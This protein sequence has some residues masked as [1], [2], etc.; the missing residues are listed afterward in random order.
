MSTRI[1]TWPARTALAHPAGASSQAVLGPSRD[2][3][4]RNP[5]P[6]SG[7]L[8]QFLRL[9]THLEALELYQFQPGPACVC[10]DLE[11]LLDDVCRYWHC[12]GQRP[13]HL[14][15]TLGAVAGQTLPA[16]LRRQSDARPPGAWTATAGLRVAVA[17]SI[18]VV[19][20]DSVRSPAFP[21][22]NL[23]LTR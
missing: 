1:S 12:Y 9:G 8:G 13:R 19:S 5:L 6:N 7:G 23:P 10:A 20:R 2:V 15:G 11:N 18:I 22:K 14:V 16:S 17:C 21:Q 4:R 3:G